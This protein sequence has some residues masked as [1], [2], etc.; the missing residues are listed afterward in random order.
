MTQSTTHRETPGLS[1]CWVRETAAGRLDADIG[2]TTTRDGLLRIIA[3]LDPDEAEAIDALAVGDEIAALPETAR[4][5]LAAALGPLSSA[6]HVADVRQKLAILSALAGRALA[7][8]A[9]SKAAEVH[10]PYLSRRDWTDRFEIL[11][12]TTFRCWNGRVLPRPACE[13]PDAR[14]AHFLKLFAAAVDRSVNAG[15][16]WQHEGTVAPPV[17]TILAELFHEERRPR[18]MDGDANVVLT[19]AVEAPARIAQA[20][21]HAPAER[22]PAYFPAHARVSVSIQRSLRK[23]LAWHCLS[24]LNLYADT[25]RMYPV[26]VYLA[27]DPFPGRRRADFTYDVLGA[28]WVY[29]ALHFAGRPLRKTLA[30]IHASFTAAGFGDLAALYDPKLAKQLIGETRRHRKPLQGILAGEAVVVNHFLNFGTTLAAIVQARDLVRSLDAFFDSLR[31]RL[32]HL[33]KDVDLSICAL[34]LM[35]EAT[36]ALDEPLAGGNALRRIVEF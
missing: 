16:R 23:W 21:R 32:R 33:Y 31:T 17:A 29:P 7:E 18:P 13:S 8:A 4:R 35:L 14:D 24:D 36:H 9:A 25:A 26:L 30:S 22:T 12:N 15:I 3:G 10:L 5:K 28:E 19:T 6:D 27:S 11:A 2:V 1:F 34:P 20:W